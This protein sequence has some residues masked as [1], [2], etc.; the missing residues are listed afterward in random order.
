MGVRAGQRNKF[1]RGRGGRGKVR[2]KPRRVTNRRKLL[3]CKLL[4]TVV[5]AREERWWGRSAHKFAK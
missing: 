1:K 2:E 5:G 4:P 3:T